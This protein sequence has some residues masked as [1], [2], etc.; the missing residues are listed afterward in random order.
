MREW[1]LAVCFACVLC[2]ILQQL[3]S[4]R[5]RISVINLVLTLY[6]LITA[7]A[8]LQ[9][10]QEEWQPQELKT[11][12]IAAMDIQNSTLQAAS[13]QLEQEVL[14]TLQKN[15]IAASRVMVSLTQSEGEAQLDY[16]TVVTQNTDEKT[17]EQL[18][19]LVFGLP[20]PVVLEQ[21]GTT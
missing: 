8:P 15:G 18:V 20:V 19:E 11:G 4:N 10:L 16:V 12:E 13:I 9:S 7:F 6:I 1:T 3:S 14:Y 21:E 5:S 2:G 17:I